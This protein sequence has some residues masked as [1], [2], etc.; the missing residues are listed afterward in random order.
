V[1]FEPGYA[2]L[3]VVSGQGRIAYPAGSL[4]VHRGSTI[5]VPYAAGRTTLDG[6]CQALR[7]SPP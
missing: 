4:P 2:I 6:H 1:T 5:L 7:C 3:I